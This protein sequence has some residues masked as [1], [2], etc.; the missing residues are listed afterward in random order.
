MRPNGNL[1]AL[2]F[3]I[4]LSCIGVAHAQGRA[5]LSADLALNVPADYPTAIAALQAVQAGYDLACH[6]VTVTIGNAT[7]PGGDLSGPFVGACNGPAS[8]TVQ[9]SVGHAGAVTITPPASHYAWGAHWGASYAVAWMGVTGNGT[10]IIDVGE[11]SMMQLTAVNFG[12]NTAGNGNTDIAVYLG[13]QL[14]MNG[15]GTTINHT[16]CPSVTVQ[17]FV[18]AGE[19]ATVIVAGPS[20]SDCFA[21]GN[22]SSLYLTGTIN[23]TAFLFALD[24]GNVQFGMTQLPASG[25]VVNAMPYMAETN[26]TI[27]TSGNLSKVPGNGT[28]S[29]TTGGQA[30]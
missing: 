5:V 11:N 30:R 9:G 27:E 7:D 28:P 29:L 10:D 15:P 16:A 24:G 12:C 1:P 20:G 25:A 26:G 13:S 18:L 4:I 2:V 19:G 3:G 17:S 6:S 22:C 21:L 14:I 8:V 23:Y